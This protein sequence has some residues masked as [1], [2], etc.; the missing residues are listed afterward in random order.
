MRAVIVAVVHVLA[1]HREGVSLV[2]DQQ[3]VG[4]LLAKATTP[5][6]DDYAKA[7]TDLI[8]ELADRARAGRA[9][10]SR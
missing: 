2:V 9:R 10:H 8:Q 1:D 5:P 3:P 6:F 7:K 4:A